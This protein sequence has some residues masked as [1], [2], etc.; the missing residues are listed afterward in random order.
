MHPVGARGQA[1]QA[2]GGL[3]RRVGGVISLTV[4]QMFR[5]R[6]LLRRSRSH[7][8]KCMPHFIGQPFDRPNVRR[9]HHIRPGLEQRMIGHVVMGFRKDD[10]PHALPHLRRRADV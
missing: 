9:D 8:R 7:Q 5:Q 6:Q 2:A 3:P 4:V 10:D 1:I